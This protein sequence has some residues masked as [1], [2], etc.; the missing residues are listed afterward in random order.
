MVTYF[1]KNVIQQHQRNKIHQTLSKMLIN[2]VKNVIQPQQQHEIY[3]FSPK[4]SPNLSNR[5]VSTIVKRNTPFCKFR[6]RITNW[7]K[8]EKI[9]KYLKKEQSPFLGA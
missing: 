6:L 7:W 1:V 5:N 2:L 3:H 9:S 8:K 4:I